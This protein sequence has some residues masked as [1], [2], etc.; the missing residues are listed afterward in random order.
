MNEYAFND[1]NTPEGATIFTK[2]IGA[3][4]MSQI[5]L[6]SKSNKVWDTAEVKNLSALSTF[7]IRK[8]ITRVFDNSLAKKGYFGI[9]GGNTSKLNETICKKLVSDFVEK[10]LHGSVY[11]LFSS[12]IRE[13][14]GLTSDENL[15]VIAPFAYCPIGVGYSKVYAK[16][17]SLLLQSSILLNAFHRCI[18]SNFKIE[19]PLSELLFR[20][21]LYTIEAG[22]DLIPLN[23]VSNDYQYSVLIAKWNWLLRNQY[24][25]ILLEQ[26]LPYH[27]GETGFFRPRI[28]AAVRDKR[29]GLSTDCWYSADVNGLRWENSGSVLSVSLYEGA[30]YG[31]IV[32]SVDL[33]DVIFT[34]IANEEG[35]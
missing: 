24:V 22:C 13:Q 27:T 23:K 14:D 6:D 7:E 33:K 15:Y 29:Y 17:F 30:D 35:A 31:N 11:H 20:R 4:I 12:A 2:G 9:D 8:I 21:R 3:N 34:L 18:D 1:L 26:K 19:D 28:F 25:D 16:A 32:G 10:R 5:L